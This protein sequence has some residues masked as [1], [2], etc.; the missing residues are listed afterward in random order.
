VLVLT[1]LTPAVEEKVPATAPEAKIG[2]GLLAFAAWHNP[3][4]VYEK[5][6]LFA[7][8]IVTVAVAVEELQPPVGVTVLV[9]V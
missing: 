3:F 4:E 9:M 1:K 7:R 6:A 8:V 5:V 2:A